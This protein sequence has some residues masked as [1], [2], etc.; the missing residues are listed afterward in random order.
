M[1]ND[2]SGGYKIELLINGESFDAEF[3]H[4]SFSMID[5]IFSL[6]SRGTVEY[7]DLSGILGETGLITRGT[8]VSLSF[9]A[10]KEIITNEYRIENPIQAELSGSN[11]LAGVYSFNLVNHWKF[12][13][14]YDRKAW[15]NRISSV[16]RELVSSAGFKKIVIN[17]TGNLE[18]WYKNKSEAKLIQ[19][20][21]KYAFS[22]DSDKTPFVA[23]IDSNNIFHF[24]SIHRLL[25]VEGR[26]DFTYKYSPL[27]DPLRSYDTVRA[28]RILPNTKISSNISFSYIDPTSGGVSEETTSFKELKPSD[29]KIPIQKDSTNDLSRVNLSFLSSDKSDNKKGQILSSFLNVFFTDML[30][31]LVSFNPKILSGSTFRLE[32]P[33]SP[34]DEGIL[35]ER[36]SGD[37]LVLMSEHIWIGS[38]S[39]AFTKLIIGRKDLKVRKLL[40]DKLNL[41]GG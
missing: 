32:V 8:P 33:L 22:E 28:V 9:G 39:V 31:I 35:S 38:E 7:K 17:D 34:G 30:V 10:E 20:M 11:S 36:Y 27:S 2:I 12:K 21:L 13:Q 29:K 1:T 26:P 24:Q 16:V 37:Y 25:G 15:T 23:F 40:A 6:Y 18:N 19:T 14:S 3:R 4:F 5:S 41:Y